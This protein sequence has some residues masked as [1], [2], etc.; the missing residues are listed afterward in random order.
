MAGAPR[1]PR[2]DVLYTVLF[3]LRK[4]NKR[5]GWGVPIILTF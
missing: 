4:Y 1:P 3:F 5:G 2:F